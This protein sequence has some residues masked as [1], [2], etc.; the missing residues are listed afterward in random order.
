[1]DIKLM[2]IPF[3]DK[4]IIFIELFFGGES[5]DCASFI[6]KKQDLMRAQIVIK[7]MN[8]RTYLKTLDVSLIFN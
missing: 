4:N 7:T 3:D 2:H 8:R 5:W 6:P 1:M